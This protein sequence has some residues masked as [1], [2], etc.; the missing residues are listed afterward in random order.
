MVHLQPLDLLGDGGRSRQEGRHDDQGAAVGGD[1]RFQLEAGQDLGAEA[2]HRPVIDHGH[3]HVDGR[4]GAEASPVDISQP[5]AIPAP[6]KS[7]S[8]KSRMTTATSANAAEI[9]AD[10]RGLVQS[11][12]PAGDGGAVAE[13]RLE[14]APAAGDQMVAGIVLASGDRGPARRGLERRLVGCRQGPARHLELGVA[15]A[16]GEI[17][18]GVAVAI[19]GGEVEGGEVAA[20]PQ[21]GVDQADPLDEIGPVDGRDAAHA[22]DDVAHRDV[23][24]PLALVLGADQLLPSSA[25]R[26][27]PVL[28]PAQGRHRVG[29]LVAQPLDELHGEGGRQGPGLVGGENRRE[30]PA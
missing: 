26:R 4:E 18:D 12:E 27:Q 19:A 13:D 5:A 24:R 1:A 3:R 14:A 17:L 15:G 28:E 2:V 9:E 7:A 20:S 10:A 30:R 29:V 16:A 23:H 21:A 11:G 8:G 6:A 22:G 25:L